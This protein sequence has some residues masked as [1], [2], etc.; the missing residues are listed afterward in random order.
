MHSLLCFD[1]IG[2][3]RIGLNGID[4]AHSDRLDH[5]GLRQRHQRDILHRQ[6]HGTQCQEDGKTVDRLRLHTDS[7]SANRLHT[8]DAAAP[9]QHIRTVGVIDR[10]NDA[11]GI[12]VARIIHQQH[13]YQSAAG[14]VGLPLFEDPSGIRKRRQFKQLHGHSFLAKES[15]FLCQVNKGVSGPRIHRHTKR[16]GWR[17]VTATDACTHNQDHREPQEI[18]H[19]PGG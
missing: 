9:Q 14:N 18:P 4:A 19:D 15:L 11:D 8:L 13:F 6:S 10:R 7:M 16:R 17:V 5:F 2:C 3:G 12:G 1:Q